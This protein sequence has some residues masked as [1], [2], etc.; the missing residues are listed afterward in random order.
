MLLGFSIL[1]MDWFLRPHAKAKADIA[2]TSHKVQ[3]CTYR[4]EEYSQLI[5]LG[6]KKFRRLLFTKKNNAVKAVAAPAPIHLAPSGQGY[7]SAQ[8]LNFAFDSLSNQEPRLDGTYALVRAL[9]CHKAWTIV[10]G[11]ELG[12]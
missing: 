12:H 11:F 8:Q 10:K 2:P 1:T 4:A 7:A 5:F 9:H 3:A 6:K